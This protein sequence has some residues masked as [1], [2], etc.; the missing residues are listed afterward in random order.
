MSDLY[1][2]CLIGP[3]DGKPQKGAATWLTFVH[4][5]E[6][7]ASDLA[8]TLARRLSERTGHQVGF[9]VEPIAFVQNEEGEILRMVDDIVGLHAHAGDQPRRVV[10][11]R[12]LCLD[13]A[14]SSKNLA[15]M[16]DADL[17]GRLVEDLRNDHGAR[18]VDWLILKA[19]LSIRDADC[20][21]RVGRVVLSLPE[22]DAARLLA[23]ASAV[24]AFDL[25]EGE[26]PC[27]SLYDDARMEEI[28]ADAEDAA[29]NAWGPLS[30]PRRRANPHP[31][32]SEEAAY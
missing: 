1:R 14:S 23:N 25:K 16:R 5:D 8:R 20:E 6:V 21:E 7:R 29:L 4:P 30:R 10:Q 2:V 3:R 15:D 27:G 26:T 18:L 17:P 11:A 22:D 9:H 32:G 19:D 13:D 24:S 31:D 28:S 12:I